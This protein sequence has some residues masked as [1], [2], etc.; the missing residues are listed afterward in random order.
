MSKN[1]VWAVPLFRHEISDN[2][3]QWYPNTATGG[4]KS[5]I[6]SI[7]CTPKASCLTFGVQFTKNPT[8]IRFAHKRFYQTAINS[9][10]IYRNH[11]IKICNIFIIHYIRNLVIR[12]GYFLQLNLFTLRPILD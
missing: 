7:N 12:L 5:L 10:S 11:T 1:N 2:V 8:L 6:L 9:L 3:N 4:S